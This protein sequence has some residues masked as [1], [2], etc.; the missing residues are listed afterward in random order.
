MSSNP[1]N[2][3]SGNTRRSSRPHV[4]LNS[5]L[6][7]ILA[8][9]S[10]QPQ[11]PRVRPPRLPLQVQ[12]DFRDQPEPQSQPPPPRSLSRK[13]STDSLVPPRPASRSRGR[14]RDFSP[15]TPPNAFPT[16]TPQSATSSRRSSTS[17]L[18]S[19]TGLVG[20]AAPPEFASSPTHSH[21]N[22][23]SR[24]SSLVASDEEACLNTQTV[25]EK[26][27][28]V[29]SAGLLIYRSEVEN[30]DWMHDPGKGEKEKRD[31]TLWNK[32]SIVNVGGVAFIGLG[33]LALFVI[34][35]AL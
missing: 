14:Y 27:N 10:T 22:R 3:T 13:A 23:S 4:R 31:Y 29:P 6:S 34:F 12:T 19:Q 26:F 11:P 21:S 8:F 16:G 30:D 32:R 33:V 28:V 5:S 9:D 1:S 15:T 17:S 7:D 20:A 25:A 35:P 24:A 18:N 2:R